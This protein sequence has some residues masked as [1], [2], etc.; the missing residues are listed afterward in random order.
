MRGPRVVRRKD[1]VA[2]SVAT[3]FVTRISRKFR[4]KSFL[5]VVN[6]TDYQGTFW[7]KRSDWLTKTD[8]SLFGRRVGS[9]QTTFMPFTKL[10]RRRTPPSIVDS[11]WFPFPPFILQAPPKLFET[12]KGSLDLSVYLHV[13]KWRVSPFWILPEFESGDRL[14]LSCSRPL[15]PIPSKID[16]PVR[17]FHT[18]L[19]IY[20]G[21]LFLSTND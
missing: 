19:S 2:S 17:Y 12:V 15:F 21:E 9:S 14:K 16:N 8:L 5:T 13:S 11:V 4:S 20:F 3:S 10:K 7:S 1:H 18:R 6:W